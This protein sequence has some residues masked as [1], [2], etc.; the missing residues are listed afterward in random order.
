MRKI[1]TIKPAT[2]TVKPAAIAAKP[3]VPAT[4]TVK[5]DRAIVAAECQSYV[6]RFYNGASL[7]THSKRPCN[8]A[9]YAAVLKQPTHKCG[10]N[11]A[12][13]RDESLLA[14]IASKADKSG[15]FDPVAILADLGVISRLRSIGYLEL[16]GDTATLTDTGAE[17]ARLVAK[18]A[19]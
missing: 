11:G 15:A 5:P 17:R 6:A 3:V 2:A 12:S 7:T 19:A 14:L 10:P 9:A 4:G 13:S 18:R 16:R 8:A 1:K